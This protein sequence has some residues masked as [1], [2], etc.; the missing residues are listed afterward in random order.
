MKQFEVRLLA[1]S[2]SEI[3]IIVEA[4]D[5]DEAVDTAVQ[6]LRDNDVIFGVD[7]T[8]TTRYTDFETE[9]VEPVEDEE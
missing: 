2:E 5:Q 4:D 3:T 1:R 7:Y 9:S 8:E 6:L